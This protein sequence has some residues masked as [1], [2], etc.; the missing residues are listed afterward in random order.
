MNYLRFSDIAENRLDF[1]RWP[2]NDLARLL[3]TVVDQAARNFIS[4]RIK[5]TH[6][7]A[8]LELPLG[9]R[10]ADR[11]QALAITRQSLHGPTIKCETGT[12]L[13]VIGEPLLACCD[14]ARLCN[15]LRAELLTARQAQ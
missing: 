2:A 4:G 7:L 10:N 12:H 3:A 11:Q 9:C 6:H 14:A 1:R 5:A 15:Q 13:Q 8:P